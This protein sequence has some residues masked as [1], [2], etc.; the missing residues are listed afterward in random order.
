MRSTIPSAPPIPEI[1]P[2]QGGLAPQWNF[3]SLQKFQM[4]DIMLRKMLRHV[5]KNSSNLCKNPERNR[6]RGASD[7]GSIQHI[8]VIGVASAGTALCGAQ[9]GGAQSAG[10]FVLALLELGAKAVLDVDGNTI[11]G[12]CVAEL[13]QRCQ[14]SR[15]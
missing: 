5:Q 12:R 15:F 13:R 14:K 11:K 2:P 3:C 7:S 10:A 6:A 1:C 9:Q 8:D 4:D